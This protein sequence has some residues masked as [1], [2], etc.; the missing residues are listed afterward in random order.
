[1]RLILPIAI[2]LH[3]IN[4]KIQMYNYRYKY[5]IN[6]SCLKVVVKK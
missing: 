3:N 1:M 5:T 6:I 2:K 4:N